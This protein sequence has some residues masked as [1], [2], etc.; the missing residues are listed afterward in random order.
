MIEIAGREVCL[1]NILETFDQQLSS[2]NTLQ[3]KYVFINHVTVCIFLH[4]LI[5]CLLFPS[6]PRLL[7]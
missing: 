6:A 1:D 3:G 4:L 5:N 2:K 7:Y